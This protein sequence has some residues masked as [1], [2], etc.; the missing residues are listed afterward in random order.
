MHI[1]PCLEF[2]PANSHFVIR[3]PIPVGWAAKRNNRPTPWSDNH[4]SF[5]PQALDFR[6]LITLPLS[7]QL[8]NQLHRYPR[9]R[10]LVKALHSSKTLISLQYICGFFVGGLLSVP[11]PSNIISR[12]NFCA[13]SR[14][15]KFRY[16]YPLFN[17]LAKTPLTTFWH[18]PLLR[19]CQF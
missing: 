7:L 5:I 15:K 2:P 1:C 9:P 12:S 3:W 19:C 16:G 11:A 18:D 10:A 13:W 14:F 8:S 4:H 17:K 6:G